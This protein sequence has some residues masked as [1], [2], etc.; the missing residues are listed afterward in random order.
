M[1]TAEFDYDLPPERIAQRPAHPRDS[2]RLLVMNRQNGELSHHVFRDLPEFLTPADVLVLNETRVIPARIFGRKIPTGGRVEILLIKRLAHQ[3]WETLVGGRGLQPGR[4]IF[5]REGLE[6]EIQE[7]LGGARRKVRFS[8]PITPELAEIGEMPLPPY[9]HTPLKHPGEYQTIFA[10]TPG[11]VAA[12]TAGLHF[13]AELLEKIE[14]LGINLVR[15]TLHIG[16]DTFAPVTVENPNEH[17][18]H[19]EW[20][21]VN[22]E[23][24]E[25]VNGA[26][27]RNGRVLAVGTTTVRA[28]ET[29]ARAAK[30]GSRIASSEGT[31]DLFIL[32]DF[33]FN[34][35]DGMITNFHLPRSSLLMMVS[36]FAGLEPLRQAYEVAID[37]GYR[38]YSFGDA[39][40]IL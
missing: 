8:E 35:I 37:E 26:R 4:R 31:T 12:P 34:A 39:M 24:V 36:A 25:A 7:N 30:Q 19:S 3:T 32:P 29:A 11:S 14:N 1:R 28:L 40:L 23:V 2:S 5:L 17:P 10:R 27:S 13:T 21:R 22:Q 33:Q 38:F 16:L 9:I 20:Y 18:I 15:I 6:A